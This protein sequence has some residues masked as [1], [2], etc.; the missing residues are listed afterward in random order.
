MTTSSVK[1]IRH[2]TETRLHERNAD[3]TGIASFTET[4]SIFSKRGHHSSEN[5]C[6]P[7]IQICAAQ[8]FV[9]IT[10]HL[11]S[12]VCLCLAVG[13]G[14]LPAFRLDVKRQLTCERTEEAERIGV[15]TP[16]YRGCK[17]LRGSSDLTAVSWLLCASEEDVYLGPLRS[18]PVVHS[19]TYLCLHLCSKFSFTV[20]HISPIGMVLVSRKLLLLDDIIS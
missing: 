17:R 16:R 7:N 18:Q 1:G 20:T 9:Q 11:E 6:A 15:S 19:V 3:M 14:G 4:C 10:S 5:S 8:V 12:A 13:N 2:D